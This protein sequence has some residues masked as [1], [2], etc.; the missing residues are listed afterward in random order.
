MSNLSTHIATL[1]CTL[2]IIFAPMHAQAHSGGTDT[3]GCH[4]GT[5]G[6]HCHGSGGAG[7]PSAG[8]FMLAVGLS[9]ALGG[10]IYLIST[11]AR[12]SN[13]SLDEDALYAPEPVEEGAANTDLAAGVL[14]RF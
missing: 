2:A 8:D 13:S 14:F 3:S 4:A 6:R 9:F 11:S 7:A 1:A 10:L 5:S 12:S